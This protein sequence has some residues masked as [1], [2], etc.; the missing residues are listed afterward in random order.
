MKKMT[1][2]PLRSKEEMLRKEPKEKD[3]SKSSKTGKI[4]I[5]MEKT[6]SKVQDQSLVTRN[7]QAK[8]IKNGADP[9]ADLG[10]LQHPRLSSL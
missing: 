1:Q 7:Y 9:K 8:V 4:N 10:L 3:L 6:H 5:Y 2:T